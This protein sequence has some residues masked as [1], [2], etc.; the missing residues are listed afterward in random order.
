M[1]LLPYCRDNAARKQGG[2]S[3]FVPMLILL[4]LVVIVS[5]NL[6][7]QSVETARA[8]RI[9]QEPGRTLAPR[10]DTRLT[11]E[12]L[13]ITPLLLL[14]AGETFALAR[15]Y[16]RQEGLAAL[17]ARQSEQLR[18]AEETRVDLLAHV[19]HDLRAPLA[20]MQLAISELLES[21]AEWD[22]IRVQERLLT[23]SEEIDHLSNR[24]CHLLE[25]SRVEA[26]EWPLHKELC[27]LME[28]CAAALERLKSALREREVTTCFP[29]DPLFIECDQGQIQTVIINLLEN[30]VKYT[31]PGSPLQL[32][33]ELVNGR[34]LLALRDEG[35]GID[36]GDEQRIFAKYYRAARDEVAGTGLG[37]AISK[38]IIEAHGGDIGVRSSRLG[39]EF[40]FSLPSASACGYPHLQ[41]RD[42]P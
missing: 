8:K 36:P 42:S 13:L 2:K 27:D 28:I 3:L 35:P 20:R 22:R 39:A 1:T 37:L 14:T 33:G 4:I 24:V 6:A 18:L 21:G 12:H 32:R 19:S 29:P 40:W 17:L 15:L 26:N 10:L 31:P 7:R 23:A 41:M 11:G 5:I 38:A 16:R 34:V 9:Q 25:M 30:A